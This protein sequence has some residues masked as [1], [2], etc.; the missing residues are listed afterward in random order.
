VTSAPAAHERETLTWPM[1]GDASRELAQE[2]ADSRFDPEIVVAVARGGLTVAGALAYALGV[3]SCGSLNVELYTGVGTTLDAPVVLPPMLDAASLR[4]H[5]VL[6]VDDVSDS[7][8]TISLVREMLGREGAEVRTTCLYSKPGT[9][10]EPDHVWRHTD[11]WIE[12]PWSVLPPV[13]ARPAS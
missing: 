3:K 8:R 2:I 12:F 11:R 4:G 9:L 6:L 5:R 1:F 7:G 10:H 13:E